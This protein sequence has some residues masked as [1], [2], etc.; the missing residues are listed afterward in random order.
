MEENPVAGPSQGIAPPPFPADWSRDRPMA[1]LHM[2]WCQLSGQRR[3]SVWVAMYLQVYSQ[4][5]LWDSGPSILSFALSSM[6]SSM[7]T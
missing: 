6:L 5:D 3:G 2:D 7:L 1:Y 4:G